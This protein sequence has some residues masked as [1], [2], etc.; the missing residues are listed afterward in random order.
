MK[1]MAFILSMLII[2]MGCAL[3]PEKPATPPASLFYPALPQQPRLQFLQ[4]ISGESDL[5]NQQSAFH[6]FIFGKRRDQLLGKPYDVA[7]SKGKIYVIDRMYNKIVI[8]DLTGKTM[9]FLNDHGIGSLG[10]PAGIWVSE[11]DIKYVADMQ[12]KQVVAFDKNDHFLRTYGSREMFENPVDVAVYGKR[13]YVVDMDKEQ[14]FILDRETGQVIRTIGG[15]GEFFKPSNVTVG[16]SG[17]VFVTD[18]FHFIIKKFSPD[19]KFLGTIGFHGDQIGGFARPK[20]AA[21][22]KN[23][24]L[25]VVDAAFENVQ[26]FD[27]Q[28]RI[29]LFFGG[30][31]SSPG[32]LYLPAGIAVDDNNTACFQKFADPDFKL[33]YLVYV[34]NM[35]GKN[36]LNIYGFGHWVGESVPGK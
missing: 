8:I 7:A 21:V 14:L 6:E 16:P 11:A 20:G 28:G 30:P 25:Y 23:G 17:N 9:S 34:T 5:G 29:L 31:G 15:K 3:I 36:M 12:R 18:A 4:S 24:R 26:I 1:K 32:N 33:E 22:D 2:C 35:F 10:D 27:D 19:G 13:I